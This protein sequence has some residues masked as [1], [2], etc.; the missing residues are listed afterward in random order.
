MIK[1]KE[2]NFISA[3]VYVHNNENEIKGFLEKINNLLHENFEQYE[4]I[5]V[6]DFSGDNSCKIINDYCAE[7]VP[8]PVTIVNMSHKH[9]T[10]MA[11]I[12]GVDLAI[13]D[14]VYEFDS[15]VTDYPAKTVMDVYYKSLEGFD[16]VAAA[17]LNKGGFFSS[18]FYKLFNSFNGLNLRS[19]RFRL[20][21]RR[22]INRVRQN[23]DNII[24]RKAVY[25][26]CGLPYVYMEYAPDFKAKANYDLLYGENLAVDSLIAFTN[27]GYRASISIT[28]FMMILSVAFILYALSIKIFG[29]N[30]S[31]GWAT[32]MCVISVSF[33]MLFAVLSIVIKYLSLILKN[34]NTNRQYL[35][36]SINKINKNGI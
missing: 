36:D 12:A 20:L 13:G 15:C 1:D 19:E 5:C 2:K 9:G 33:F 24:Y 30:V 16:I 31:G 34:L 22:V 17:P 6:N 10:E 14:F 25:Y 8:M 26:T 29:I 23:T 18:L 4:I 28:A 27:L 11:M 3:V 7:T 35:F 21:S 32:L